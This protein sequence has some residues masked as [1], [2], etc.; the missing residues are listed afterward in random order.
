MTRVDIGPW[1]E[2]IDE[3]VEACVAAEQ[4]GSQAVRLLLSGPAGGL[5]CCL[6]LL[7]TESA[8]ARF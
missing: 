6:T 4:A 8:H 7:L 5:A 3:F 2:T 1:G